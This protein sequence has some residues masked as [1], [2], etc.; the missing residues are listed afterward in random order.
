MQEKAEGWDYLVAE[1]LK[2]RYLRK[3]ETSWEDICGRVARAIAGDET[4]FQEFRELMVRKLFLPSSPVL[5]N[6]GTELGQL[7]SCFVVPVGDSVEEIFGAVKTAALIQKTGGGTGFNFSEIRP[8]GSPALCVDGVASGPVSFIGLFNAATEVIKQFGKRRGANIGILDVSHDDVISF[9][10]AKKTEGNLNNFNLSVMVPDSFMELVETGMLE[11]VWNKKTGVKVE[12]IFAEI[13]EGIWNNGEPGLLFYDRI[14]RDN[15]TPE[16]GEITAVNPCGEEPLLSFESCNLGSLN[17][18]NFIINRELDWK[19]LK[20]G[21]KKA[22]RF[23][24]NC[25]DKNAYPVPEIEKATKR[26]RKIGLGVM[27]FH[28]MLLK[29]GLPYDSKG[30][31]QVGERLMKFVTTTAIEESRKLAAEKGSFPEHASSSW[32]FPMRNAAL[33]AI[34]P[35]GTISILAG[36]SAGIEPV[37][38]WVYRRTRTIDNE[39]MLVHPLFEAHFKPNLSKNDYEQML[40][41]IYT[42]GTLQDFKAEIPLKRKEKQLF[43]SALDINWKAHI[44]MQATFQRHC[45]AGISKTINMPAETEREE[46]R[47]AL[48]YAWKQGLKGLTI[49]RTKSREQVVYNLKKPEASEP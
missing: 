28:D 44:D 25:I 37:F 41:H 13:V 22:V 19:F 2:A 38:S 18:S 45:H 49:Y 30:A 48:I 6:A 35:T 40:D 23:L 33:T 7:S 39:F 5:M 27:G 9:I 8:K 4:E 14:N 31:L 47:K 11:T 36:C 12:E 34:A 3:G 24:D 15:F 42:Q 1:V 21:I 20:A 43:R 10:R 16:L 29:L 32:S 46:I 17:L 26:T